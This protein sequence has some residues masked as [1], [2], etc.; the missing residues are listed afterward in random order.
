MVVDNAE[1]SPNDLTGRETRLMLASQEL[2]MLLLSSTEDER[3]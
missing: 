1:C 3:H 2:S